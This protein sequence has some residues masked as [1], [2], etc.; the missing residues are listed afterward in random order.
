MTTVSVMAIVVERGKKSREKAKLDERRE[1][2][3]DEA[4]RFHYNAKTKQ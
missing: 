2:A 3:L 4:R 1:R